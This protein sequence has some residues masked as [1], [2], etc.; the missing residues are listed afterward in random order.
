MRE[1][2]QGHTAGESRSKDPTLTPACV[3]SVNAVTH[4]LPVL[5]SMKP[6]FSLPRYNQPEVGRQSPPRTQI[7]S[8]KLSVRLQL[9]D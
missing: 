1:L 5:A 2:A 7:D 4:S 9:R 3:S 8:A 6:R